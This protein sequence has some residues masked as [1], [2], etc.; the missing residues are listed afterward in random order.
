MDEKIIELY[1]DADMA[2]ME[3]RIKRWRIAL[4]T[5]S[6]VALAVC[7]VLISLTGTENAQRMELTVV[8]V[9]TVAGWIVIYGVLFVAAPARR[10]LDHARMLRH[11]ERQTVA[12]T[13]T[14]TGE[15]FVIRKSVAVRRVEVREGDETHRLLVCESRA[16]ALAA[17][18]AATLYVC[19]GYV[20]AYG[21]MA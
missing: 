5:L 1:S 17:A 18:D 6:A 12:G 8:A 14:V 2:R 19:H 9:S 21:V 10:E 4:F 7:L 13:V 11:E 15:R 20:A 16:G 3:R